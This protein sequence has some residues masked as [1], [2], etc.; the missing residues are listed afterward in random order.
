[1]SVF[2]A[3]GA[4]NMVDDWQVGLAG[5]FIFFFIMYPLYILFLRFRH[6]R[7]IKNQLV[8]SMYKLPIVMNPV[9]LA[10]IFSTKVK[11]PQLYAT[12]LNLA[13]RSILIMHNKKGKTTV[14]IGPKVDKDLRSFEKFL[15]E[16]ISQSTDPVDTEIVMNGYANHI[17]KSKK[18]EKVSGSKQYVFWWLLRDSLRNRKIIQTKLSKRYALMIF[19]FG[20]LGSLGV[21]VV[22][23]VFLR[24]IQMINA[25]EVDLGRI[26]SSFGSAL[27]LWVIIIIPMILVSF[28]LLKYRGRMLGRHWIVTDQYKRYVGQM[29][30]FREF[31]RL[32]HK[33]KLRFESKE[34]HKESVALTRPYA[35]A[36]GY[37]K[38]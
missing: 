9:E 26:S 18:T 33:D 15:I 16:Q 10:Y 25:G 35:I 32:T 28:G 8:T 34:L 27:L 14:E 4:Y 29:D 17:L 19:M 20:V 3:M 31:V 36:C 6:S 21:L 30:A 12:L 1:M 13:N 38:K 2:A 22:S 24:L 11:K 37:I 7:R 23:I 5:V